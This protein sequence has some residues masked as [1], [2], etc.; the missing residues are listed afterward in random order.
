M[1]KRQLTCFEKTLNTI[2]ADTDIETLDLESRFKEKHLPL[3][4][5]FEACQGELED[6]TCDDEEEDKNNERERSSF[7]ERFY[8]ISGRVKTFIKRGVCTHTPSIISLPSTSHP[9]VNSAI[10]N[11]ETV[12]PINNEFEA[13]NAM[14]ENS[15]ISII[16]LN[17]GLDRGTQFTKEI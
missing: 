8:S 13:G 12:L 5:L 2:T 16:N 1:I 11:H 17:N 3:Q 4:A 15:N 14:N 7:D 9:R 10:N 6:L